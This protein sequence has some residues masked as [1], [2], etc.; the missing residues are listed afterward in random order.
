MLHGWVTDTGIGMSMEQQ[1]RVFDPFAQGDTS[2]TRRFGGTGL[3]LSITTQLVRMMGGDIWVESQEKK[4]S[5]FH[6]TIKLGVAGDTEKV[7]P[8]LHPEAL[9]GLKVLIVDDNHTNLRILREMAHRW[10]LEPSTTDN[11]TDAIMLL[12]GATFQK[13]PFQLVLLDYGMPDVD[14]YMMAEQMKQDQELKDTKIILLS[15]YVQPNEMTRFRALGIDGY[16]T[17]PVDQQ[18][19]YHLIRSVFG[20]M[21]PTPITAQLLVSEAY[22]PKEK[23]LPTGKYRV[24]LVEDN[25]IN[26]AVAMRILEQAGHEV[27]LAINGKDALAKIAREPFDLVLM[28][29][30]MPIMDGY[31]ATTKI[32][33][34]EKD[35]GEH[36]SIIAIT[37]N[38]IVGDKQRCLENGMD[39][40][41]SKPFKKDELLEVVENY[42]A[43]N[44]HSI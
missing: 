13:Q 17:K 40:Y 16:L 19:L 28:D 42:S 43:T 41:L 5:T 9:E 4:G 23:V 11:A 18:A 37:A 1:K 12:Q 24:L 33:E 30:H 2:T 26:Q 39:G 3:G 10:K 38:A 14:G 34:L 35:S 15:S 20:E 21:Q 32:R 44:R 7:A 31:E 25:E 6:F 36:V 22:P 27:I 8:L 29:I